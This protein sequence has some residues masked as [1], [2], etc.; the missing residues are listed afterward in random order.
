MKKRIH[1]NLASCK[2][3]ALILFRRLL[4]WAPALTLI[5]GFAVTIRLYEYLRKETLNNQKNEYFQSAKEEVNQIDLLLANSILRIQTYEDNMSAKPQQ[6]K[7]DESF[8]TQTLQHTIFHRLSIFQ[9]MNPAAARSNKFKLIYGFSTK[10]FTLPELVTDYLQSETLMDALKDFKQGQTFLKTVIHDRSGTVRVTVIMRSKINKNIYFLFTVPFIQLLENMNLEFLE[11]III[12]AKNKSSN[13]RWVFAPDILHKRIVNL[14]YI[15]S[16]NSPNAFEFVFDKTLP[17]SSLDINFTFI[18]PQRNW[19]FTSPPNMGGLMGI[20]VTI[21]ISYLFYVLITQ[22]RKA[23]EMVINKT[24]DLEKTASDLQEALDGK[25]KFLGKISHEIR[26]PLNLILGMIELSQ[27][28][29]VDEEMSGYLKSMKSSGEHLLSMIDDLL[30]LARAES[31]DLNFQGREVYLVQFLGDIA[32]LVEQDCQKKGLQLYC[33]LD[34][35]LPTT[36]IVDP[37]RLRQVLLNLLRNAYKYTNHGHIVLR[38][39]LIGNSIGE[40]AKVKFE[41]EDTGLGIPQDKMTKIFDAFFQVQSSEMFSEG[42]VGLGL[43]IVKDI[44]HKMHGRVYVKSR[45]NSGSIFTVELDLQTADKTKWLDLYK[46]TEDITHHLKI[47][48]DNSLFY[49]T[50]KCLSFHTKLTVSFI[51]PQEIESLSIEKNIHEK[52]WAIVDS[53]VHNLDL[54][55]IKQKFEIK[56]IIVFGDSK[57]LPARGLLQMGI[58]I[59]NWPPLIYETLPYLGL[60][61]RLRGRMTA[62]KEVSAQESST[63]SEQSIEKL[64]LIIA[65]DDMGNIELYKGYFAKV[66][67][68]IHYATNGQEAWDLYLRQKP[69]LFILDVRMPV[70]DGFE[71]VE[72]IR[73]YEKSNQLAAIHII[74]VTADLQEYTSQKAKS[75]TQVTLMTKPVRKK[76]LFETINQQMKSRPS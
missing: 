66:T 3:R 36:V 4:F 43:S 14:N 72:K 17:H 50:F 57:M 1:N 13:E 75:F 41:I 56:N 46:N 53:S 65:D 37:N 18:Y 52:V 39:S 22:N 48:S 5:I 64:S 73:A 67:W 55:L 76:A 63:S 32:K 49:D 69:D 40:M 8:L 68:D 29:K 28:K 10:K 74:L 34:A 31:N 62:K 70:M 25:T 20:A 61:S 21:T 51:R 7:N 58:H 47:I 2:T 30:D 59:K 6:Y 24:I 11:K 27:E 60:A 45:P 16:K 26:T 42:G 9:D 23:N 38:A 54:N 19:I 35:N 44:V 33:I 15:N 71:L 12:T